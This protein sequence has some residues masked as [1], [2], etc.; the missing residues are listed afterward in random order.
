MPLPLITE[1]SSHLFWDIDPKL[2]DFDE[3]KP[4]IIKRVLEY[5]FINDWLIISKLYGINVIAETTAKF[6]EL[7]PRALS[8]VSSFSGLPIEL[9]RCYTTKPSTPVYWNF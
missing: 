6:R 8:F 4:Q 5:G 7:D 3:H 1:F 9:F 2:L